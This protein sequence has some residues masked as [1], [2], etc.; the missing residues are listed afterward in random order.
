MREV[1][2]NV[3]ICVQ[4]TNEPEDFKSDAEAPLL[5]RLRRSHCSAV[6]CRTRAAG[7]DAVSA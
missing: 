7:T 3:G 1:T 6:S 5:M 2:W 4:V